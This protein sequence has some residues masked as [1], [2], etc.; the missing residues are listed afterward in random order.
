MTLSKHGKVIA[1]QQPPTG[2]NEGW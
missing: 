2:W 1:E